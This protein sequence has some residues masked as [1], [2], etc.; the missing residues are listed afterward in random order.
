[1]ASFTAS[2]PPMTARGS[3][4]LPLVLGLLLSAC[5]GDAP[6]PPADE[7]DP[8]AVETA[9]AATTTAPQAGRYTGTI[10][11]TRRVPLS[12]KMMGTI[13]R[14]SVEEGDRV[15]KGETLVRIR[16]Q[17]VEAQ[18]EQVQARLREARAARDNAETQFER[19]RA[20]REKDSATEQEFDNAQTAYERA[21]AQVEA[22]E[23]RLAE[24]EDMLTYATLEAPI[25]GYV[26][27]KQSEQGALAA[28]GRPL[29]TVETLDDL[30]AVV[31]VP[32]EDVNQFAVGD[33]ATVTIGAAANVHKQGV[34]TQVN[35]SGNAVSRQFTVQVRLPRTA[36]DE[37][38]AATALKSGMYAEVRH[39]T[40]THSTL[41][42][43]RA[44]LIERGQL[45]GLY[46]VRDG[47]ALLRWVRTGS[48]R[49][50]RV[51][52]LSGL[53]PGETYVTDATPRIAN[54]QPIQAE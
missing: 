10:Q 37:R 49:G 22:L 29:L 54:G 26:V 40:G 39:Q 51:E 14:L 47:H 38:E 19:I 7:R 24:T 20:L 27:E 34:V 52:V 4:V 5:G 45:T 50:N 32:A 13:T 48:Q 17:N 6:T 42:V 35:P 18:R 3:L 53:R 28:P 41:T 30:K 31:Q 23:S 44:A 9:T 2:L 12:T 21:Q 33:S 43:P 1:M 11:G 25:D 8:V 15:R 46:A 16:S 36:P